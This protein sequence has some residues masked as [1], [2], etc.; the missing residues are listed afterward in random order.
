MRSASSTV[1]AT[2]FLAGDVLARF[3][4]GYRLFRVQMGRREQLDGI[5]VRVFEDLLI[6]RVY[7]RS[8]APLGRPPLGA[9]A[10]RI[11]EGNYVTRLVLQVARRIE[12]GYGPAPNDGEPHTGGQ[13][14]A[15][16]R[17]LRFRDLGLREH[18]FTEV[19]RVH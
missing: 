8:D 18:G 10:H 6:E 14:M 7:P 3:E 12:L 9:L 1:A 16:P 13:R 17:L 2:G 11:A 19:G 4:R 5:D 15:H